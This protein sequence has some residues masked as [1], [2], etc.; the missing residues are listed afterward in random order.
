MD[1]QQ[2]IAAFIDWDSIGTPDVKIAQGQGPGEGTASVDLDTGSIPDPPSDFRNLFID[3][4][5]KIGWY[6]R[7]ISHVMPNPF[8]AA[9]VAQEMVQQ[10]YGKGF[11]DDAIYAR[12]T[13]LAD[14]L[15]DHVV[16]QS[17]CLAEQVFRAKLGN[18]DI[19]FDLE[20][21]DLSH[22][23]R[24]S[25]EMLIAEDDDELR[26]YGKT[27][28]LSLFEPLYR[29]DFNDLEYRFAFYLE[30]QQALQWWHRVAVRQ[31]GEYF[32]R[33]WRRERIWP[34]FVAMTV[35]TA[36]KPSLLGI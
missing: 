34:D 5:V 33:G 6:A 17:E 23:V 25:Y 13:S 4:D 14:Q 31:R 24:K 19:R 1:Y 15:R 26:R 16:D 22:R 12:R 18:G 9:R 3:T 35:E 20:A 21:T 10:M 29:R 30:E 27:V 8:R 11:D 32:L 2:H 7:R 28:Q 36:G